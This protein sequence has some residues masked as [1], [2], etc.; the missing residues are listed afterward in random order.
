MA[1]KGVDD[2][3]VYP[4]SPAMPQRNALIAS[5]A[6][7]ASPSAAP[8]KPTLAAVLAGAIGHAAVLSDTPEKWARTI[9]ML[10]QN[11]I[12]P[13]GYEDFEKGRAAAIAAVGF[14]PDADAR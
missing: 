9:D 10:K 12:D 14:S 7:P 3:T 4:N 2:M 1:R 6:G 8:T 5:P 13:E 11:G